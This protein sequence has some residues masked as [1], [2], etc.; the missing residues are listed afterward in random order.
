MDRIQDPAQIDQPSFTT[1]EEGELRV[2]EIAAFVAA[3]DSQLAIGTHSPSGARAGTAEYS[4]WRDSAMVCRYRE[5]VKHHI[6]RQRLNE[7][8]RLGEPAK[9]LH[10]VI[11][12][13]KKHAFL[14]ADTIAHLDAR[15]QEQ[16]KVN[17]RLRAD[18]AIERERRA[19]LECEVDKQKRLAMSGEWEPDEQS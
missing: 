1:I 16:E 12:E 8:K 5:A 13:V 14:A 11:A 15:L 18:L 6:V 3:I 4:A 17:E 2:A 19:E 7:L 10:H 9:P